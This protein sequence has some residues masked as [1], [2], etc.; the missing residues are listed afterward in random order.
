LTPS[1]LEAVLEHELTHIRKRDVAVMTMASF[2]A[3]V[4]QLVV[5]WLMWGG[6]GGG[7]RRRDGGS[8]AFVWLVSL[9]VWLVSFFLLRAL[10]RYRE[11]AADRGA[12]LLT[13]SPSALASALL[14][15]SGAMERVPQRD[16]REVEGLSAFFIVPA[17]VQNLFAELISTHPPL[18]KRLA[19]LERLQREMA[20]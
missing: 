18:E 3:T 7:R 1:E 14:K 4:A 11:Y 2:F 12:A 6:F 20:Q 10:S 9:L 5:R 13:G 15:I 16:L 19:Y 8:I 17:G